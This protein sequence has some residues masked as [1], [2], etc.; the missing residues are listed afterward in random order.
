MTIKPQL[1][2]TKNTNCVEG[3]INNPQTVL[4]TYIFY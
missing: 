4:K 2:V 3:F 1:Q